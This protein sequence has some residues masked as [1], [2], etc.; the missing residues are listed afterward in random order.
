MLRTLTALIGTALLLAACGS[1]GPPGSV[2]ASLPP[3]DAVRIAEARE[4]IIGPADQL[5]VAVFQADQLNRTVQVDGQGRIDL[6][7]IGVMT[8]AGKSTKQLSTEIATA[9]EAKYMRDP[10]VT[11]LVKEAVSQKV[12]VE[13]SVS[14]PGVYPVAGRTTLL[15]TIAMARGT[16]Q[17]ANEKRVAIFRTV[18]DKRAV[19]VFDLT[20]IRKGQAPDP[21]VYGND[22]VVVERSGVKSM[23]QNI[24]GVAPILGIFSFF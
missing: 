11:V 2:T 7:L 15:Q 14:Q 6:P 18:N 10:Q 16:E 22:V 3:P 13:G 19:A 12:T 5:E 17:D 20:A 9:L 1:D 8:A 4:Y 21:D 23:L 24:T